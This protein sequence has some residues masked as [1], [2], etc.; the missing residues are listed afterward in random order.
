[1]RAVSSSS[2]KKL[3]QHTPFRSS[4]AKKFAQHTPFRSS[5][6]K[7]FAQHTEIE[8]FSPILGLLGE[9]FRARTHSRASRAT[10]FAHSTQKHGDV[11]TNNT[12]ARP[13][14]GTTETDDTSA[15][16]NCTKNA[17]FAPEK[18]M[19]VS[20]RCKEVLAKVLSVS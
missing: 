12:T 16:Q 1:M 15:T 17:H 10:N 2:A 14:Q 4:S 18:A 5:S 20:F 11:E 19:A 7:K 13:Q 6:A 8:H 3:T 9:L